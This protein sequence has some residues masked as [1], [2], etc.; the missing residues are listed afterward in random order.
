MKE[1]KKEASIY[2]ES[3]K[4]N[5]ASRAENGVGEKERGAKHSGGE[6]AE[7]VECEKRN[8]QA[9]QRRT[10]KKKRRYEGIGIDSPAQKK[11][12]RLSISGGEGNKPLVS[13]YAWREEKK[14]PTLKTGGQK[15]EPLSA[16]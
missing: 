11:G 2:R 4:N 12:S 8:D 9:R 6:K 7:R 15:K 13:P 14:G 10:K 16:K 5:P 1:G 3:K